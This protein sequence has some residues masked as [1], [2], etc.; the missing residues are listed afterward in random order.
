MKKLKAIQILQK[1]GKK[2]FTLSEVKKLLD[3]KKDN[4]AYKKIGSLINEDLLTRAKKGLYYLSD[5]PPTD[6]ELAN[7]L[8]QPSYISLASGLNFYGILIQTPHEITSVTPK[9]TKKIIAK[10][11]EFT[12]SHLTEK[13]FF[14]YEKEDGFLI[15]S[16]EKVLMDTLFLIS[17]GK[18]SLDYEEFSLEGIDKK[19]FKRISK[20]IKHP[21]FH[22]FLKKI[23]L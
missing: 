7:Y 13:Y 22:N 16:P 11:K 1:S 19:K 10:E 12:Y 5:D 3:I 9:L 15:G 2:V 23:N 17:L 6:F 8:Y 21:A 18:L 4:T 20:E 14:G